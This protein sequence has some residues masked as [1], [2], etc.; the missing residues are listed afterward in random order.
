MLAETELEPDTKR[1]WSNEKG[2]IYH[3]ALRWISS[4]IESFTTSIGQQQQRTPSTAPSQHEQT[5]HFSTQKTNL[6]MCNPTF[7]PDDRS[8]TNPLC[9][10]AAIPCCLHFTKTSDA[11]VQTETGTHVDPLLPPNFADTSSRTD[12][13]SFP[14]QAEHRETFRERISAPSPSQIRT[15]SSDSY[16][17][18]IT[19]EETFMERTLVRP[20][21]TSKLAQYTTTTQS[22]S[23]IAVYYPHMGV[24]MM[25]VSQFVLEINVAAQFQEKPKRTKAAVFRRSFKSVMKK[26]LKKIFSKK[27]RTPKQLDI[28]HGESFFMDF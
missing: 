15:S 23:Q 18:R 3:R 27:R 28:V 19:T 8:K 22:S 11:G 5:N 13:L 17:T 10:R 9:S 7:T 4:V 25:N 26:K 14:F 21:V 2:G 24:R 20:Q 1:I 12:L 16:Y 6:K